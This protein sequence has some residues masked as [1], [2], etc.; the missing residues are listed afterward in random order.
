MGEVR[1]GKE[2]VRKHGVSFGSTIP[3]VSARSLEGVSRG[4]VPSYNSPPP[5]F[6]IF[7][8]YLVGFNYFSSLQTPAL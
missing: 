3:T 4:L 8:I 2:T 7:G 6:G 5:P 1:Q